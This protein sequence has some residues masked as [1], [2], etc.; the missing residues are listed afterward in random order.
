MRPLGLA[1]VSMLFLV[2]V[3]SVS[4]TQRKMH[5]SPQPRIEQRRIGVSV[6]A[7]G[8]VL[9]RLGSTI[10]RLRETHGLERIE[11][12][13]GLR[14][15][16]TPVDEH[17]KHVLLVGSA[18]SIATASAELQQILSQVRE[19]DIRH[20]HLLRLAVPSHV[21]PDDLHQLIARLKTLEGVKS[22]GVGFSEELKQSEFWLRGT[23]CVDIELR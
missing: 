2:S 20:G 22:A 5:R 3:S 23:K 12:H 18:S 1:T 16:Y 17:A 10:R 9:G 14:S 6:H 8:L 7:V 21:R 11:V 4:R 13:E 19:V 15:D